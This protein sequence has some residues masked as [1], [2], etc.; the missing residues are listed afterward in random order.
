MAICKQRSLHTYGIQIELLVQK[1]LYPAIFLFRQKT[2]QLPVSFRYVISII[3]TDQLTLRTVS[4][5]SMN[6]FFVAEVSSDHF[7]SHY[8]R[9][10]LTTNAGRFSPVD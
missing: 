10:L 6:V 3:I 5:L 1:N 8:P 7:I 9:I 2:K 4:I